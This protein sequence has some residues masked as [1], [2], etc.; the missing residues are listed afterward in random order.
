M[1][2]GIVERLQRYDLSVGSHKM[3]WGKSSKTFS[4]RGN[5]AQWYKESTGF[6]GASKDFVVIEP[7]V[8]YWERDE[9]RSLIVGMLH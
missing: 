3:R 9:I 6:H 5:T 7:V 8:L 2:G 4:S 1:S